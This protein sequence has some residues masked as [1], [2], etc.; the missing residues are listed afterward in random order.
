MAFGSTPGN[1]LCAILAAVLP[2]K[3]LT[4]LL[5]HLVGKTTLVQLNNG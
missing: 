5:P 4:T 3:A 2:H 1:R